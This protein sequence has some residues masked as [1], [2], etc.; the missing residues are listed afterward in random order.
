MYAGILS[1]PYHE[2]LIMNVTLKSVC[3]LSR[4][5]AQTKILMKCVH[6][7]TFY[8]VHDRVHD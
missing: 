6:D 5:H 3:T 2:G 1:S 4:E 8:T 7:M